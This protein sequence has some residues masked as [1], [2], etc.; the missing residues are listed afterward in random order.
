MVTVLM[1]SQSGAKLLLGPLLGAG[2]LCFTGTESFVFAIKL[3]EGGDKSKTGEGGVI[4]MKRQIL[5]VVG[6]LVMGF[7]LTMSGC[8]SSVNS[9]EL[10]QPTNQP[11]EII[12]DTLTVNG[13]ET[14]SQA[15]ARIEGRVQNSFDCKVQD[16]AEHTVTV[17]AAMKQCSGTTEAE[18]YS[19]IPVRVILS[20]AVP[21]PGATKLTVSA[22]DGYSKSF[23]LEYVMNDDTVIL[24]EEEGA[25]HMAAGDMDR[26]DASHWVQNVVQFTVE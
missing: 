23:V 1:W 17:R 20:Q 4:M 13:A 19:G 3:M 16:F 5:M 15:V 2:R 25:L 10:V 9:N 11:A 6:V 14:A 24:F 8:A 26:Y 21:E 22:A 18:D 12:D 7:I